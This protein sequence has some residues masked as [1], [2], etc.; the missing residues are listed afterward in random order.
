MIL[1]ALDHAQR[2]LQK[3]GSV[4]AIAPDLLIVGVRFQVCFVDHIQTEFVAQVE[5]VGIV[6]VVRRADRVEVK[7]FHCHRIEPHGFAIQ[8]LTLRIVMI[9]PVDALDQHPLAI[10]KKQAVFHFD[11]SKPNPRGGRL[12]ALARPDF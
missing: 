11:G 4:P 7:A 6:R 10:D 8:S 1:V 12:D 5:P 2:P 3:G 9:V